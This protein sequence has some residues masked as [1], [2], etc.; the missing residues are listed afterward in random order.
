MSGCVVY[1]K[2]A[3]NIRTCY[4]N[5]ADGELSVEFKKRFSLSAHL[6]ASH[7]KTFSLKSILEF[8]ARRNLWINLK[9]QC[10]EKLAILGEI[11]TRQCNFIASQRLR[12]MTQIWNLYAYLYTESTIKQ[13]VSQLARN[14]RSQK[15]PFTVL[16]GA[17]LFSWDREKI[18]DEEIQK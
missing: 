7:R 1:N 17:A 11:L 10:N 2:L 14:L 13:I 12:R 18:T 3:R 9:S 16:L 4:R 6:E 8:D 15:R 5:Y